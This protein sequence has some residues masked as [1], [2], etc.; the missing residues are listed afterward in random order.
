MPMAKLSNDDVKHVALLAQITLS[1]EEVENYKEQLSKVVEH[2]DQLSEVDTNLVTPTSQTTGVENIFRPDA[3]DE[4]RMLKSEEALSNAP[5]KH[6][7][8]FSVEK[9]LKG[10]DE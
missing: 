9:I 5:R 2:I 8:Y 1:E 10:K 7:N 4:A 6:N 3:V